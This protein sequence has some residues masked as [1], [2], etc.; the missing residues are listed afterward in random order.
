MTLP[1]VIPQLLAAGGL[2]PLH[3]AIAEP[4][5]FA[6]EA[7]VDGVRGLVVFD[8]GRI[9][10]RNR[11]GERRHWLHGQPLEVALRRLGRRL[12]LLHD[13]TVLDGEL[14]AERFAGT[15]AALHGS[16]KHGEALRY[17]VFDVPFLAGVDLRRLP[18]TARRE[19]LELLAQAFE[20][21][22]LLSPLVEPCEDLAHQ[23][24]RGEVEGIVL[25]DRDSPYRDGSRLGWWKIKERSWWEREAWRFDKR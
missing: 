22:T 8:G 14:V 9:E 4:T 5:R 15:M 6:M 25:K 17:V 10:T 2:R 13:G 12:P 19:R 18:W 21:P 11:R 24:V 16:K 1:T 20:P 7:K 3:A 23:M